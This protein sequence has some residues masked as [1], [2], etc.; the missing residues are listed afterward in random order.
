MKKG[1]SKAS[2]SGRVPPS[3]RSSAATPQP[4]AAPAADE[5]SEPAGRTAAGAPGTQ[6]RRRSSKEEGLTRS[7]FM[8][9]TGQRSA[10]GAGLL[11]F[12]I[13]VRVAGAW[14]LPMT[15]CDETFNYWEPAHWLAFGSGMQT[16]EYADVFALRS[17][18]FVWIYAW[19]AVL[20]GKVIGAPAAA[21]VGL[22]KP[23]VFYLIKSAIAAATACA[24]IYCIRGV[25]ARF[26]LR[27]SRVA[28]VVSLASAGTAIA[29]PQFLPS[30]FAMVCNCVALG[31]WLRLDTVS[32][33]GLPAKHGVRPTIVAVAATS[34]GAIVGWP[35]AALTAVPIALDVITVN[36][37]LTPKTSNLIVRCLKGFGRVLVVAVVCAAAWAGA[38]AAVDTAYYCRPVFSTW[39]LIEYNVL[40]GSGSGRGPELY[41]VEPWHFFF[42]NLTLN[43]TVLFPLALVA[44]VF[45]VAVWFL[46]KAGVIS[47]A[48]RRT[49]SVVGSPI[50]AAKF[51]EPFLLWFAFWLFV[52]HKEERFM[53][54]IYGVLATSAALVVTG[55]LELSTPPQLVSSRSQSRVATPTCGCGHD[56]GPSKAKE[57]PAE[58]SKKSGEKTLVLR[59]HR[60]APLRLLARFGTAVVLS[61]ALAGCLGRLSAMAA[62]YKAPE[63]SAWELHDGL[64]D[65]RR[66]PS[67]SSSSASTDTVV[68]LGRDWFRFPSSFFVPDGATYRFAKTRFDG[69]LPKP[70]GDELGSCA[71]RGGGSFND[72]NRENPG[73]S[74]AVAEAAKTCD[75]YVDSF[76][77][78]PAAELPVPVRDGVDAGAVQRNAAPADAPVFAP[79]PGVARRL[80]D[81]ART[82]LLC[83]LAYI[84]A[85]SDGCAKWGDSFALAK[86][87]ALTG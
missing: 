23:V 56:H 63:S 2:K 5:V 55:A 84:P 83:R 4:P 44:P 72:L 35:F 12:L 76:V 78:G 27:A 10:I 24:E 18:L 75:V 69:A 40:A 42:K 41:G 7:Q 51:G 28:F 21:S 34:A 43:F 39:Q 37:E 58:P 19:P 77:A 11:F 45:F 38:V 20:V 32:L 79:M 26:G 65:Y 25:G 9:A 33:V 15:D 59:N 86:D 17:W 57:F 49:Q 54:P 81:P 47:A 30:S 67:A 29:A 3:P 1:E 82:T 80:L 14:L 52:P 22:T 64:L 73:Q 16:W 71:P 36:V 8:R 46:K 62:F 61:V 48:E 66:M 70:F 74:I 87:A 31:A 50:A 53:A 68:C 6:R 85:V 60:R 13:A